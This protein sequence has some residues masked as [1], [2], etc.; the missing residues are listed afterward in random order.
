MPIGAIAR[1]PVTTMGGTRAGCALERLTFTSPVGLTARAR[2]KAR[3]D[4]ARR[5]S[6]HPTPVIMPVET[7]I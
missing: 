1:P 5:T 6:E 3:P 4:G 7:R 2:P